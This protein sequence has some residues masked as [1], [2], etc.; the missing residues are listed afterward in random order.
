MKAPSAIDKKDPKR[1]DSALPSELRD[2]EKLV[3]AFAEEFSFARDEVERLKRKTASAIAAWRQ[4]E[5]GQRAEHHR[6]RAYL[7]VLTKGGIEKWVNASSDEEMKAFFRRVWRDDARPAPAQDTST[8]N[9]SLTSAS[10]EA[11]GKKPTTASA[12]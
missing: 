11:E 7:A 12:F 10:A 4:R 3:L 1:R 2:L 5:A 6:S 9:A 8:K